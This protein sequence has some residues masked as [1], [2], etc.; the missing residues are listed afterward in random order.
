MS[1]GDEDP[2]FSYNILS[3][4]GK[5]RQNFMGID[6]SSVRYRCEG[7]WSLGDGKSIRPFID[8]WGPTGETSK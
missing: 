6:Q 7:V 2:L 3:S 5:R 1:A 8:K 4:S